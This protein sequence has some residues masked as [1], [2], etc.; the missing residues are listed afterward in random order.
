MVLHGQSLARDNLRERQTDSRVGS[1]RLKGRKSRVAVECW[2]QWFDWLCNQNQ[3][4]KAGC[5]NIKRLVLLF[6][7]YF[8]I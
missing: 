4:P 7:I 5:S 1:L 3:P 2:R 6:I 8:A